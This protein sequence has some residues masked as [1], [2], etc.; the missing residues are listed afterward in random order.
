MT[1]KA[2]FVE[3]LG[4]I[5]EIGNIEKHIAEF[6][7]REIPVRISGVNLVGELIDEMRRRSLSGQYRSMRNLVKDSLITI[8]KKYNVILSPHELYYIANKAVNALVGIMRPYWDAEHFLKEVRGMD[9]TLYVLT[10][11]DNDIAKKMLVTLS[12]T[13]YF[14]A[15]ISADLSRAM[16]PS[17]KIYLSALKRAGVRPE[18]SLIVSALP[19]DVVGGALCNINT[20]FVKRENDA[21]MGAQKIANDLVEVVEILKRLVG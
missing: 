5:L 1:I 21:P 12:I 10:S 3:V 13:E 19:E 16:K 17:P 14:S 11:L 7:T 4:T 20:I 15:I 2:L 6:V 18:E 9:I 8:T